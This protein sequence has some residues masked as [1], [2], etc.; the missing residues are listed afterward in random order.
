M[1]R[2]TIEDCLLHVENRFSLCLLASKRAA[3]LNDN[4]GIA[5]VVVSDTHPEKPTVIALREIAL[6]YLPS[7]EGPD[8]TYYS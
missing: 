7:D 6:G 1:A 5:K 3:Q 8:E 4:I 2:V